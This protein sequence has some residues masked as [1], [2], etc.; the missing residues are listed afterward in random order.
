MPRYL[1]DQ[2]GNIVGRA[3]ALI[4]KAQLPEGWSAVDSEDSGSV[5]YDK[6]KKKV[7][8]HEPVPSTPVTEPVPVLDESDS[9][10]LLWAIDNLDNP[11]VQTASMQY[12]LSGSDRQ[13]LSTL[14]R[15]KKAD[16]D[17]PDDTPPVDQQL[18]DKPPK[19]KPRRGTS[20]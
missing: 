19:G 17:K 10:V 14:K 18:D 16:E 7:L 15:L 20:T 12:L 13:Y 8:R 9:K 3:D 4:D 2:E 5:R 1:I 6:A 11:D